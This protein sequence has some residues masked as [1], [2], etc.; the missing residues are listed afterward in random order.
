[1]I[2]PEGIPITE[3]NKVVSALDGNVSGL[4]GLGQGFTDVGNGVHN[5]FQ[6]LNGVYHAPE[7]ELLV[8][9]TKK[10][11]T[12]LTEFGP[13]LPK[14][15]TH[16]TTLAD[17]VRGKVG[18]LKGIRDEA[19]EW[20]RRKNGN[21]EWQNDQDMIDDN[22]RMVKDVSRIM[23]EELPNLCFTAA[24]EIVKLHG[25]KTWDPKTGVRDGDK[26]PPPPDEDEEPD[27]PA[28]GTEE[29]RDKPWWQDCLEFPQNVVLGVL[30]VVG[31]TVQ[32]I[33]TLVPVL[34]LLAEIPGLRD[35]AKNTLH[36][37]MPTW[38]DAGNAWV[39]LGT[40]VG[41]IVT[42]PYQLAWA[43]FDAITGLD[44]R[45]DW[46][47]DW[48]KMG[49]TMG[50]G[51]LKGFVAWDEWSKN[52]G[53]AFG[54][55]LTNIVATVA[56]GGSAGAVKTAALA[57]KFG[58][59]SMTVAK[60]AGVAEKLQ[61][62]RTALHD[63]ALGAVTKIPKVGDVV[64]GLSKIPIVGDTFKMQGVPKVDVDVPS[65]D[66]PDVTSL[67]RAQRVGGRPVD[68]R[69]LVDTPSVD[70]P[71]VDAP[72]T[73]APVADSPSTAVSHTD[74]GTSPVSH[75]DPGTTTP[76]NRG[77]DTTTSPTTHAPGSSSPSTRTPDSS[78]TPS[79]H[80]PDSSTTPT[81][82]PDSSTTPGTRTPDSTTSPGTRTPDSTTPGTRAP[83][84]QTTPGTRTPE[85]NTPAAS[86][87]PD[88]T[89]HTPET[90]RT[91]ES[92][93][94][95]NVTSEASHTPDDAPPDSPDLAHSGDL[96]LPD[97][98][99]R[100]RPLTHRSPPGHRRPRT[101]RSRRGRLSRRIRRRP[102]DPGD[103]AHSETSRTPET[104]HT[105]ET[106]RTRRQT[107]RTPP[108][109]PPGLRG[110]PRAR[111]ERLIPRIRSRRGMRTRQSPRSCRCIP[112]YPVTAHRTSPAVR[113]T[114]RATCPRP[115]AIRRT[116]RR[117][118]RQ[119][120]TP[121]TYAVR[122]IIPTPGT[123]RTGTTRSIVSA[124]STA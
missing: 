79:S 47:K 15:S 44:T 96:A 114:S 67:P 29:E 117:S 26:P 55:A 85:S 24:N 5:T 99:I 103:H 118:G 83:E 121:R 78:T 62:A 94:T 119:N 53:K 91:P 27:P 105:P 95:P 20:H 60:V 22:N 111:R 63:T 28:W 41:Q 23:T 77:P 108:R 31:E 76:T 49:L 75:A 7:R 69:S 37:D 40:F 120:S 43:G 9:S 107:R 39:G 101:H 115:P 113:R 123:N 109:R 65:V 73:H 38:Q 68:S 100:R 87:T 64:G 6:R 84:T 33:L 18:T 10:I 124:N 4:S 35:F 42:A 70:T 2:K 80:A 89:A 92:T 98:R 122:R 32:S 72:T 97:R 66:T 57:G 88:A 58:A 59:A 21:P 93:H 34:P 17:E 13:S 102:P 14:M 1:M 36:W 52:P 90:S 71:H 56:S 112:A 50:E 51:M 106:P 30:T 86:H 3:L 25:G 45:P 82:T 74:P 116:G 16:L 48:G 81:R 46:V 110:P 12:N 61:V 8:N 104:P 19:Y 11:Q 54:M